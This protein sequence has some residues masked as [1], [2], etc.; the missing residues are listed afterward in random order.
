[1]AQCCAIASALVSVNSE[2]SFS[3]RIVS[4][5]SNDWHTAATPTSVMDADLRQSSARSGQCFVQHSSVVS[6][7]VGRVK[8]I[9]FVL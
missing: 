4:E 3:L 9:K 5:C 8:L 1:M 7:I 6:V 2:Q